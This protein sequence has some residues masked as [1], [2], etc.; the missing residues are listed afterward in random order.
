M[1]TPEQA[2]KELDIMVTIERLVALKSG[3]TKV[4]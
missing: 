4:G 3:R 1:D 2:R